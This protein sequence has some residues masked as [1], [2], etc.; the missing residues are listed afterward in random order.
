[1]LV[2]C[3]SEPFSRFPYILSLPGGH[4]PQKGHQSDAAVGHRITP[5]GFLERVDILH[6]AVF[7]VHKRRV[8]AVE[9]LLPAKSICHDKD[10]VLG[11]PGLRLGENGSRD[12]AEH[13][14]EERAG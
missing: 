1:V 5:V 12:A 9:D 2:T 6:L 13:K 11:L 3:A 10:N 8:C 4:C 7:Q 14:S